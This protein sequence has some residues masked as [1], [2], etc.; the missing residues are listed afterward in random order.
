[1]PEFKQYKRKGLSEMIPLTEFKTLQ[2]EL[3]MLNKQT[4]EMLRYIKETTD[5]TRRNVDA[6]R[7]L[8]GNLFSF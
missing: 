5:Y 8:G 7:A 2:T 6:T 4:A 1:M 3:Q